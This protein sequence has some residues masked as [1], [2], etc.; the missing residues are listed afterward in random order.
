MTEC[1]PGNQ[2]APDP[3]SRI[4]LQQM[5][6][7]GGSHNAKRNKL[8]LR[9]WLAAHPS[10]PYHIAY[11]VCCA[12]P[13]DG[14]T[15][16]AVHVVY[17]GALFQRLAQQ[18]AGKLQIKTFVSCGW[19]HWTRACRCVP[20]LWRRCCTA[21]ASSCASISIVWWTA[22]WSAPDEGSHTTGPSARCCARAPLRPSPSSLRCRCSWTGAAA[23]A[24]R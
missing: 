11:S 5:L 15:R 24:A 14:D 16:C 12:P 19:G 4:P 23:R 1:P 8:R 21:W 17:E 13:C 10:C 7:R 20:S 18:L 3:P 6:D 2:T 9:R 22:A